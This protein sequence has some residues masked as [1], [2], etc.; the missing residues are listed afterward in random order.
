M[1]KKYIVISIFGLLL[2]VGLPFI[3]QVKLD[4]QSLFGENTGSFIFW[5][6]RVPVTILS[7]IVGSTL[8][9]AGLIFQNI[10]KNS[11]ATPYTLG[12]SSGAAAASVLAI[13]LNISISFLGLNGIYLYGFVGALITIFLIIGIAKLVRSFSIYTLLMSGIA[14]NF[15]FSACI[16]LIQY[17]SDYAQ[18]TSVLRWL[19]GSLSVAG[20]N[21]ILFLLPIYI[22]FIITTFQLKN[23]LILISAGDSFA[24]SKGMNV[25]KFRIFILIIVSF[26]VGVVVTIAGPIGFIGLIVPHISRL[27]FKNDFKAVTFFTIFI[28]GLLLVVTNFVAR[29][30]IPPVEIPVGIIT[31]FLGA[32]FFLFILVSKLK[33]QG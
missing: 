10:F 4:I 25:K 26:I 13:K 22:F 7:F 3:G 28:G 5:Q 19:M 27:I 29:N 18:T 21:E 33:K 17:L 12:V 24:F 23:D 11:L 15:F 30:L 9:L 14:L 1:N 6:L 16:L 32:P 2:L 20:Y 31:S 8:A